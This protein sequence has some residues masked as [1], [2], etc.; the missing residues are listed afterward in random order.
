MKNLSPNINLRTVYEAP[1]HIYAMWGPPRS[2]SAP[3]QEAEELV[4]EDTRKAL[5]EDGGWF[6]FMGLMGVA[7]GE[8]RGP[9]FLLPT[10]L[11]V[12]S[13][14]LGRKCF[15]IRFGASS[16]LKLYKCDTSIYVVL[17]SNVRGGSGRKFTVDSGW[18]GLMF[19]CI[20]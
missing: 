1:L 9:R 5:R 6:V 20:Q 14:P 16:C 3:G 8:R 11:E 12:C 4:L 15:C 13:A 19:S 10:C 7:N 2:R 17:Y 18:S